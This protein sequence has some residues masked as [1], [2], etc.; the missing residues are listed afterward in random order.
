[1]K[2]IGL[3]VAMIDESKSILSNLGKLNKSY[4]LHGFDI[5]EFEINDK[6]IYLIHSGVGEIYSAGATMLLI[7]QF[8]VELI[9]NFGIVGGL[10]KDINVGDLLIA[11]DII[12]TDFDVSAF[13]NCPRGKYLDEDKIELDCNK[14]FIDLVDKLNNKSY[15][16]VRIASADK[17]IASQNK[18]NELI[19]EFDAD[20]CEME[21]AGIIRICNKAN[22]PSLFIKTVSDN[23]DEN[24]EEDMENS[25]AQGIDKY[26]ILIENILSNI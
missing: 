7:N 1:M 22:I 18:I 24:A 19:D 12:H 16:K 23:A 17:F 14:N 26:G 2:K 4:N 3:V 8:N 9:I 10:K 5:L 21:S 11:K 15:R 25:I 20:I 13:F 6:E